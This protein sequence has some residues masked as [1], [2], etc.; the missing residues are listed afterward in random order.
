MSC[1]YVCVQIGLC[2]HDCVHEYTNCV[3]TYIVVL[4]S[5]VFVLVLWCDNSIAVLWETLVV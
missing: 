3:H 4:S 5:T 2:L 1:M